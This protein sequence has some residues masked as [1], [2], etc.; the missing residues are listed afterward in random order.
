MSDELKNKIQAATLDAIADHEV[1]PLIPVWNVQVHKDIFKDCFKAGWKARERDELTAEN[2]K[3]RAENYV[4][5][6]QG[7]RTYDGLADKADLADE[8]Q[9]KLEIA[10]MALNEIYQ[11][12]YTGAEYVAR[13]A[14]KEIGE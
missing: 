9:R 8:L 5:R 3:L 6:D 13:M 10:T 12:Q 1:T 14:L 7:L 11:R 2:A 4:L